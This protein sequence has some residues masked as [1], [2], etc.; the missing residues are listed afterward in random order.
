MRTQKEITN[1]VRSAPI[2]P[3]A[4]PNSVHEKILVALADSVS[5]L[6]TSEEGWIA[7]DGVESIFF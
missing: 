7:D 2:S 3:D 1:K 5:D 6:E 4:M